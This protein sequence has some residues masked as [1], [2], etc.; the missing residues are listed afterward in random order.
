MDEGLAATV[1][2]AEEVI[3]W[4]KDHYGEFEFWVE[5]D[6]VWTLQSRLGQ[7]I[8]KRGLPYSV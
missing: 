1:G 5:R 3:T 2:L 7:V 8:K 4:L 6:L